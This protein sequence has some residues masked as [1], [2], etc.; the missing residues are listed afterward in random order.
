MPVALQQRCKH[1]AVPAVPCHP[2]SPC[3]FTKLHGNLIRAAALGLTPVEPRPTAA[4]R[5]ICDDLQPD[6]SLPPSFP[7][8]LLR[9]L[10]PTISLISE[11]CTAL[12]PKASEVKPIQ[13]ALASRGQTISGSRQRVL[14]SFLFTFKEDPLC[15]SN[16]FRQQ[17]RSWSNNNQFLSES[18]HPALNLQK[19]HSLVLCSN[20]ILI[21]ISLTLTT[22]E[23]Q[24][25]QPNSHYT[26]YK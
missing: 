10:C 18:F 22:Q 17:K 1:L 12:G 8:P 24:P 20:V 2:R 21:L 19:R 5:H 25:L 15:S 26:N 6:T 7:F 3:K 23:T 16:T 14:F 4:A 13:A 9:F 11:V